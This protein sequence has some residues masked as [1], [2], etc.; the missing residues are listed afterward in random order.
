MNKAASVFI[1]FDPQGYSDER[2]GEVGLMGRDGKLGEGEEEGRREGGRERT[3]E[4]PRERR[5]GGR[6][7]REREMIAFLVRTH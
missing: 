5:R 2:G 4:A 6:G 3:R 1:N 7:E